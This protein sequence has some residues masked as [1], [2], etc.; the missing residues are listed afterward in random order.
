MKAIAIALLLLAAPVHA[1]TVIVSSTPSGAEVVHEEKSVGK[2]PVRLTLAEGSHT[3]VL[4]KDGQE[5]LK[6]EFEVGPRLVVLKLKLAPVRHSIDLLFKEIS[7]DATGWAVVSVRPIGR[8]GEVPGTL[9]LPKGR[10]QL[11]LAKDGF[12]DIR[13]TITV[14][15]D[16]VIELEETPTSGLSSAR[17]LAF[18]KY[19]GKWK[20]AD[21]GSIFSFNADKSLH[22]SDA[23]GSVLWKSTWSVMWPD[24]VRFKTQQV[25]MDMKETG[26]DALIGIERGQF[27]WTLQRL[28]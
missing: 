10:H 9:K 13:K 18:L 22:V 17:K 19:V 14:E 12:K 21:T 23:S 1:A 28:D 6:H 16:A 4:K 2:T 25:E 8:I 7:E 11:I 3:L 24:R 26:S 5:P 27:K 15:K 20:K